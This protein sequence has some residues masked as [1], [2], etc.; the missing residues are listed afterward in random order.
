MAV[1]RLAPAPGDSILFRDTIPPGSNPGLILFHNGGTHHESLDPSRFYHARSPLH[2]R[3]GPDGR[4]GGG[5]PAQ[6]S[7]AAP[8]S[9]QGKGAQGTMGMMQGDQGGC[10]AKMRERMQKRRE[11]MQAHMKKMQD[12]LE[13]IEKKLDQLLERSQ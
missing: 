13:R 11:L 9:Q 6:A 8:G 7:Q 3:S 12:R 2:V 5:K 4:T 10:M 1:Y